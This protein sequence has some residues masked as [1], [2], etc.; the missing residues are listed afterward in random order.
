MV[1]AW[2]GWVTEMER[3]GRENSMWFTE[4]SFLNPYMYRSVWW[5]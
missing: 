2:M 4:S 1:G 3:M 5:F